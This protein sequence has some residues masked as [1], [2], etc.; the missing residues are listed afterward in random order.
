MNT[1]GLLKLKSPLLILLFIACS[2][3]SCTS[4]KYIHSIKSLDGHPPKEHTVESST[5]ITKTIFVDDRFDDTERD[6]IQEASDDWHEASQGLIKYHFSYDYHVDIMNT[7]HKIIIIY[8]DPSDDLT[9]AFDINIHG[10]FI[11]GYVKMKDSEYIFI[12]PKRIGD[13]NTL[14]VDIERE[15]GHELGLQ[16]LP[17]DLPSVMNERHAYNSIT[18]PTIYDMIRFCET[19]SCNVDQMKYCKLPK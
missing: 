2:F 10:Y 15:L 5:Q 8:L 12:C 4:A 14:K 19:M 7:S 17:L 13:E 18:C 1:R 9:Q 16:D 3:L 6:A 11:T